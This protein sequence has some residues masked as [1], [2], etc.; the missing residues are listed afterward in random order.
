MSFDLTML[1]DAILRDPIH[2]S[3]IRNQLTRTLGST[4]ECVRDELSQSLDAFWGTSAD[5]H[6]VPLLESLLKVI[7]RSSN[8]IFVG[9]PLCKTLIHLSS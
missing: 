1:D 4:L 7:G 5:W 3:V 8:R 9:L 2:E 6:N